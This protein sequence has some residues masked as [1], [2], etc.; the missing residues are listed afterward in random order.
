MVWLLVVAAALLVELVVIV[1]LGRSATGAY[2]D[3]DRGAPEPTAQDGKRDGDGA[4]L[5]LDA[6]RQEEAPEDAIGA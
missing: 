6:Y 3:P 2:G 4:L 5:D 1:A